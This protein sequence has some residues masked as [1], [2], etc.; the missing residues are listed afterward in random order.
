MERAETVVISS[1]EETRDSRDSGEPPDKIAGIEESDGDNST[2]GSVQSKRIDPLIPYY[3]S[4]RDAM[5]QVN[6][7]KEKGLR[8]A[9]EELIRSLSS[10][11]LL[12]KA[13]IDIDK[14]KEEVEDR[15]LDDFMRRVHECQQE[16]LRIAKT[17]S[18]LK[19]TYQKALRMA[20]AATL[21]CTEVLRDR[22]ERSKE[23]ANSEEI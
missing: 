14:L 6:E 18:N 17:S 19:G 4:R 22:V 23:D 1:D 10:S 20:F 3:V 11:Q 9:R 8:L 13:K 16:I 15:P 7:E 12:Q 2:E 21:G 5:K